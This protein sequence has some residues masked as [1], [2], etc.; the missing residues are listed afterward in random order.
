MVRSF[1]SA[2]AGAGGGESA[3]YTDYAEKL[4]SNFACHHIATLA[5]MNPSTQAIDTAVKLVIS[6]A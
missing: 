4:L 2:F 6:F 5:S 3:D 1:A